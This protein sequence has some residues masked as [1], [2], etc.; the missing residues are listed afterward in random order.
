MHKRQLIIFLFALLHNLI[1]AQA[2]TKIHFIGTGVRIVKDE[3]PEVKRSAEWKAS[4]WKGER[5]H[6]QLLLESDQPL[7]QV[8]VTVSELRGPSGK[9]I[10]SD[11][12]KAGWVKF[13]MTDEFGK[14]CD[15]RK[16]TDFDSSMVADIIDTL[17]SGLKDAGRVQPVWISIQVPGDAVPGVYQGTVKVTDGKTYERKIRLKVL[18]QH[19]P[20]P[21]EWS[22]DLDLWQHPAAIAR[23][24][25]V[26][27]WSEDH[28]KVMRPYYEM[29]A[30]AGQKSITVPVIEEPW[31]H[32]TYDDFPGMI[33]WIKKKDGSWQYDYSLF[34]RY[35]NFV[36]DCGINTR[37]N[38]HTM[39]PWKFSFRYYDEA[40]GIDTALNARTGTPEYT[41]HWSSMLK[42][43]RDHLK[44]KGWFG[45]TSIAMDERP[46]KDMQEVIRL[47]KEIDPEWKIALAGD[48]HPEIEKD[49]FDY[50]IAS[51]H[52]F[53]PAVLERRKQEGKP[54]TFYTCCM[55]AY[56]NGFTFSPP[57]ENTW[58]GWYAASAG[59]TGYLRWAYNSWVKDPLQDSRFRQWPGGDTYQVYPGPQT[60]IRFEKLVEGIQDF[61][62]IRILREHYQ[63]TG[64]KAKLKELNDALAEFQIS[65]LSSTP[66]TDMLNKARHLLNPGK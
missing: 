58:L 47:L 42:D 23:V 17:A 3:I 51:K 46:Q 5:I 54:S 14:G 39:V 10:S 56:P 16:P 60:S 55:E 20:A 48:Y 50:C 45:K 43:F 31:N 13:V 8:S 6:N 28:F 22:Y 37:I 21:S 9:K 35:V 65:H 57:D 25:Q 2:S 32:Q 4:A 38:C 12:I 27:L 49:I 24:H 52:H 30:A 7:T 40:L 59:F 44:E 19:L 1:Y 53:E 11:A 29:L 41:A 18:N 63:N 66:A 36:M 61:E 33:K 15:H 64:N 62:K 34:D 26:P